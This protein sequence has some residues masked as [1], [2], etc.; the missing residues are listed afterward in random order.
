MS[1]KT[2]KMSQEEK[3]VKIMTNLNLSPQIERE[4]QNLAQATNKPQEFH[5][6]EALIRYLEDIEDIRDIEN[7]L[8]RK[9]RGEV[10]YYTSKE[11]EQRLKELRVK[12][13]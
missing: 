9:K 6:Q 7:Y 13:A 11:A 1:E 10:K 8:E 3:I 2:I 4:L 5:I 12:N